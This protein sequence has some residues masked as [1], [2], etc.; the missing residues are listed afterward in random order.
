MISY[1]IVEIATGKIV[2]SGSATDIGAVDTITRQGQQAI[3]IDAKVNNTLFYFKEGA[4]HAVPDRPSEHHVFDYAI[5][6][7]VD[8]RTLDDL[9]AAAL[10]AGAT[11]LARRLYLPITVS[12]APFDAD[13]VSRDRITHLRKRLQEGRGLPPEWMGW[14]DASNAM[15]WADAT[16]AEVLAHLTA[17]S[18]AIENREQ[19]LLVT[20]WTLKAQIEAAATVDQVQAI[21]WPE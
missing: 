3:E 20:G 5:K 16:D 15:H 2:Q 11:E 13:Q 7:W 21:A 6:Q 8:P 4:L 12:G 1:A 19:A 14:R 17:L 10:Q 9:K 18:E